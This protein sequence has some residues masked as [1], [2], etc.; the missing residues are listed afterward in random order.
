MSSF[1]QKLF[2]A[3]IESCELDSLVDDAASREACRINNAG[4]KEQLDYL[5]REGMSEAEIIDALGLN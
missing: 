1:R 3:G 2:D 5:E 4:I